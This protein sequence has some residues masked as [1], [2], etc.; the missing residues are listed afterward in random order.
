MFFSARLASWLS[1]HNRLI[2][3]EAR[4][5]RWVAP[6]LVA[7]ELHETGMQGAR[8]P[9]SMVPERWRYYA[10]WCRGRLE[11]LH[12]SLGEATLVRRPR[13]VGAFLA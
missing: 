6:L 12:S 2:C 7:G 1:S 3:N 8:R 5:E 11:G 10:N 9:N 13:R 4:G